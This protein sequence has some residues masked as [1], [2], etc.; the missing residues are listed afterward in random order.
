MTDIKVDM[1]CK[2]RL[3]LLQFFRPSHKQKGGQNEKITHGFSF[4]R[5]ALFCFQLPG[6]GSKGRA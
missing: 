4:G 6:Q 1:D 5:S 2:V 3:L